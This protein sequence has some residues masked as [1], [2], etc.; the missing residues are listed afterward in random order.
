MVTSD[1]LYRER[2]LFTVEMMVDSNPGANLCCNI[3]AMLNE[4]NGS[5]RQL[6]ALS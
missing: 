4:I 6:I 2:D 5:K 3:N 1:Y